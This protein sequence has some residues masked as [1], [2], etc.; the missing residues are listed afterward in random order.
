M[1]ISKFWKFEA[2][3]YKENDSFKNHL[4]SSLY[5]LNSKNIYLNA[6]HMCKK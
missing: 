4:A 3:G 5:S 6:S 2:K 1:K